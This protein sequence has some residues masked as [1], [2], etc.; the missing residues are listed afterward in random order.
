LGVSPIE[1]RRISKPYL[2]EK[3]NKTVNRLREEVESTSNLEIDN[4]EK[5]LNAIFEVTKSNNCSL[6]FNKEPL[7]Y[8]YL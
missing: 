2:S 1:Q 3:F 4:P 6:G 7:L 8:I 5:A